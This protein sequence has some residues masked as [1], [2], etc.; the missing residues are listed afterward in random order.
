[1]ST[2]AALAGI[3][4]NDLAFEFDLLYQ[5]APLNLTGYTITVYMKASQTTPDSDA[6]TYSP[7]PTNAAAGQFTWTL[8]H[9]DNTTVGMFWYRV[10]VTNGSGDVAT[11]IYGPLTIQA[12]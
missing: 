6:T 4:N 9:A 10:D 7:S 5:G 3:V 11:C 8:P 1:V 12:A 2:R